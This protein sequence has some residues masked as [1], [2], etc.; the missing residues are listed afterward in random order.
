MTERPIQLGITGLGY[1]SG[2]IA[3]AVREVPNAAITR[4][5]SRYSET[6]ASFAAEFGCTRC[7]SYD[8]LLD[9]PEIDG[10]I[11]MSANVKHEQDVTR[12]A[13]KGKH[14]FVTKP[15]ATTIPA[16]KNMIEACKKNRVILGVGHQVRREPA[17]RKLKESITSGELGHVR[18]VE[19]NI[20]TP[21]GLA[22]EEGDWRCSEVE[23]PGGPLVQIGIHIVDTLHYLF[24]PIRR[25]MSWQDSGGLE[26]PIAGVTTTLL[27]FESGLRGYLGSTYVSSFSHWIRV[28][29]TEKNAVGSELGGLT[30]TRDSW[31]EGEVH[32]QVA[33]G[34]RVEA[35]MPA[36]VEEM[37]EF[38]QCVRDGGSP[39]ITGEIALHHLAV[40]LAAVES[41]KQ[42]RPVDI[43]EVCKRT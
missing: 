9:D 10:V 20:S 39:E 38:V 24:G 16:A 26:V 41:G 40:I 33:S 7:A 42:G 31:D 25:V 37:A 12:A 15:I 14:V 4:C 19:A 1:W 34:A 35:P 6:A 27:E 5:Y 18:L 11:V 22:I 36:I 3:H 8:E 28:Y 32:Q 29:G 43:E 23:C 17:W 2:E 30:I 13:G 21:N